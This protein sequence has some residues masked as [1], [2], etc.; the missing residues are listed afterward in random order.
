MSLGRAALTLASAGIPVFPLEPLGKRPIVEQ[1]FKVATTDHPLIYAWWD[2]TPNANIGMPTGLLSGI[3]V[4][5]V[6][7]EH[8]GNES[9]QALPPRPM[10]WVVETPSGG[11]PY[12]FAYPYGSDLRNTAGKLGPG[13]D[14]RGE[15]GYVVVPPRSGTTAAPT[16]GRSAVSSPSPHMACRVAQHDSKGSS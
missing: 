16:A 14:T 13:L 1:G 3:L 6:D 4:L 7:P 9:L 2:R 10:T 5:D 8:G 15:G 12:W 11:F